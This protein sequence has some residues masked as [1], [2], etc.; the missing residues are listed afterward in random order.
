MLGTTINIASVNMRRRNAMMHA[1]LHSSPLDHIIMVQEP[2]FDRIGTTCKDTARD[3]AVVLGGV[4]SPGWEAHYPA[5]PEGE[6]A[7]VMAYTR[8]RCSEDTN[9]PAFFAATPR[10]DLCAH[11]CI[12]I[13]DLSFDDRTWRIINFYNNVLDRSALNALLTLDLDPITPTLVVGD[14][15]LHSRT[16]LPEGIPPSARASKLEEWAIGNL[17]VLANDA[18]VTT[19]R[20]ATHERDSTIDLTWYNDAAVE[21]ATFGNWSLDWAGSLGSNHALTRVQGFLLREPELTKSSPQEL[22]FIIDDEKAV[23][24][25]CQFLDTLGAQPPLPTKPTAD[26]V[27]E[28]AKQVHDV[29]QCATAVTM[30]PRRP[31]HPKGTPWWND[32][33]AKSADDL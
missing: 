25:K 13:L 4:A 31:F 15:N 11:P 12:L 30:K 9:A 10:L 16:W 8:K 28:L 33:C 19:R 24:W 3:G 26:E 1:L 17:L 32:D 29:L 6:R 22:G 23:E 21:D 5:I 27:E 14:F 20:G 18:G 2:W 7:K